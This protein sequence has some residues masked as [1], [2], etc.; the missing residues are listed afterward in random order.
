MSTA[1]VCPQCRQ[2]VP[3]D[4]PQGLCPACLARAALGNST[5]HLSADG[6]APAADGRTV[7]PEATGAVGQRVRYVGDY[8]LLDELARG[9]MGVVFRARQTSL[10]RIVALK[11]ILAGAFASPSEVKRF[12]TEAEHA[13][14][15]DHPHI[16]PIHE[17]G[18]HEGQPYF[19]MKLIEGPSLARW[20]AELSPDRFRDLRHQRRVA[21]L[22]VPVARAVHHA[23]QRGVLH[24]DLKP[25]NVLLDADAGTAHVT[26]FG[27][28]KRTEG[29]ATVSRSG[30]VVGTPAYMAPEQARGEKGLSVAVDVWSLGAILYEAVTG[31]VPFVGDT[32]VDVL[33]RVIESEPPSPRAVNPAI[34]RDLE[35]ICLK[36]LQKA[37]GRRYASAAALADDLERWLHGEPIA[38]RPVRMPE[39][40]AKWVRRRPAVAALAGSLIVVIVLAAVGIVWKYFDAEFHR[41]AA[42]Q[43]SAQLAGAIEDEKQARDLAER[44]LYGTRVLL[45]Q[46]AVEKRQVGQARRALAATDAAL[47]GW[48]WRYLDHASDM[49][50]RA[51]PTRNDVAAELR[52]ARDRKTLAWVSELSGACWID[53]E[54]PEEVRTAYARTGWAHSAGEPMS[55]VAFTADLQYAVIYSPKGLALWRTNDQEPQP[56]GPPRK[57]RDGFEPFM[58]AV[59]FSADGRRVYA[60]GEHRLTC[61]DRDE[62]RELWHIPIGTDQAWCIAVRGDEKQAAVG[63][64]SDKTVRLFD[65]ATRQEVWRTDPHLNNPYRALYTPDG[66]RLITHCGFRNPRVYNLETRKQILENSAYWVGTFALSNDGRLGAMAMSGGDVVLVD[67]TNGKDLRTLR[68]HTAMLNTVAFSPDSTL[69]ASGGRDKVIKLWEARSGALVRDLVGHPGEVQCVAFAPDGRTLASG[70]FDG[71]MRFWDVSAILPA[72]ALPVPY[73]GDVRGWQYSKDSRRLLVGGLW[74]KDGRTTGLIDQWNLE[75]GKIERTIG[76][77]GRHLYGLALSADERW[78]VTGADDGTVKLWDFTA[79][80]EVR[81]HF[82]PLPPEKRLI[83]APQVYAVAMSPDS[84]VYAAGLGNGEVVVWDRATG[85]ERWRAL[86]RTPAEWGEFW[87]AGKEVPMSFKTLRFTPDGRRLITI[88]SFGDQIATVYAA[89]TGGVLIESGRLSQNAR[90]ALSG[91]GRYLALGSDQQARLGV[92]D[93]H[94]GQVLRTVPECRNITALAFAPDGKRLAVAAWGETI[95]L[96][97]WEADRTLMTARGHEGAVS[98]LAFL[99]DGSRIVSG[100]HDHTAKLWDPETG[101]E[102]LSLSLGPEPAERVEHILISPDGSRIAATN[103]YPDAGSGGRT[104]LVWWA[105]H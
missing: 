56:L 26:D 57:P 81:S 59:T 84:S 4:A 45:A 39:R 18:E 6:P 82:Q 14:A 100:S 11:M 40:I 91:D 17:V 62:R 69:V 76:P 73:S 51:M 60:A 10:Q 27:L 44:R 7:A 20:L 25:A 87:N 3:A 101:Q 30:S 24:R 13:A 102:L 8:E 95:Q 71:T 46:I 68:G 41:H 78:L 35:V 33:L 94:T 105:R 85:A 5:Q 93:L 23:H 64:G 63:H 67:V 43:V 90:W 29:G 48:E 70:A 96:L 65:L 2:P 22:V 99:P 83:N 32:P 49:S 34:H 98:D 50:Q 74:H 36:C 58:A 15:L 21:E 1:V 38:A 66:K 79:G 47:R 31:R 77:H 55:N 52:F 16:V 88:A 53:P 80:T 104:V 19:S 9:G 103:G 42:E 97:D 12:R 54:R 92:Y 37:P 28:A 72:R 89:D 75:T 61:W 86:R